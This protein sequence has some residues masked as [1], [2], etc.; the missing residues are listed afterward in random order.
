MGHSRRVTVARARPF[1][2][3]VTGE[4]LDVG[5]PDREQGQRADAAPGG[6][7]PQ[8]HRVGLAR[9][10]AVS[11]QKAARIVN[12]ADN[13]ELKAVAHDSQVVKWATRHEQHHAPI[14]GPD[15]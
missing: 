4:A 13:D 12:A 7:P 3:R 14:F 1:A 6:E 9:E 15:W 5:A 2:S 11:G 8:I 10:A